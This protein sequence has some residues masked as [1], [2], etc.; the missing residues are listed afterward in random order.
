MKQIA[1]LLFAIISINAHAQITA[2]HTYTGYPYVIQFSSNGEKIYTYNAG[3]ISLYNMDHSIW[4]TITPTLAGYTLGSVSLIS[5]NLFNSDNQVEFLARFTAASTGTYPYTRGQILNESGV[6]VFDL[7]SVYDGDI[8]YNTEANTYKLFARKSIPGGTSTT[9]YALP[10]SM[11]CGH[12]SSLGVNKTIPHSGSSYVV[13]DPANTEADI[14][15]T[16]P[17][18]S[19]GNISITST[20]GKLMTALSAPAYTPFVRID[21]SSWPIGMY[22]YSVSANGIVISTGKLIK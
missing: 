6:V 13:P 15:Y 7:D 10:G 22:Y 12:C 4:K 20:D 9:V 8:H 14:Y 2:E 11:P 19:L 1:S 3:T 21:I 18:G 16:I 17:D 5:D